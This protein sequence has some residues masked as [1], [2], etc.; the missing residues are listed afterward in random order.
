M[1]AGIFVVVPRSARGG[2]DFLSIEPQRF[3]ADERRA[4][5][6]RG[7][8]ALVVSELTTE[9]QHIPAT[10]SA[11][12]SVVLRLS[13][14]TMDALH[15]QVRLHAGRLTRDDESEGLPD[16]LGE[17]KNLIADGPWALVYLD[18]WEDMQ[19]IRRSTQDEAIEYLRT[20]VLGEHLTRGF[21][22]FGDS[23]APPTGQGS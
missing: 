23:P 3:P 20:E 18:A 10:L 9:W 11:S 13:D 12:T 8:L 2:A 22:Y 4:T 1:D 15:Y 5:I 7:H 6:I 14:T 19:V 21:L 16:L 17:L